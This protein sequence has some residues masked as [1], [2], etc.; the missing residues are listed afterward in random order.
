MSFGF[1]VVPLFGSGKLPQDL[2]S[3]PQEEGIM[4]YIFSRDTREPGTFACG[5]DSSLSL[6]KQ[7]SKNSELHYI[8]LK[9]NEPLTID[10]HLLIEAEHLHKRPTQSC[11][12]FKEIKSG[13]QSWSPDICIRCNWNI[14][15][16]SVLYLQVVLLLEQQVAFIK[17]CTN[18]CV[19]VSLISWQ[20][21]SWVMFYKECSFSFSSRGPGK[22]DTR[23]NLFRCDFIFNAAIVVM[24]VPF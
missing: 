1:F 22:F 20:V 13:V 21:V 17:L 11:V 19:S 9:R 12:R 7:L 15:D 16:P 23:V 6:V 10:V 2:V 5:D 4:H 8:T 18:N 24:L 3:A 14:Q